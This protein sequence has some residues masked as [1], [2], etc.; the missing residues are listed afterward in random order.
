MSGSQFIHVEGYARQASAMKGAR[1]AKA[2]EKRVAKVRVWTAREILAES[3]REVQASH[4]VPSPKPPTSLF[5]DLQAL[6]D[7]LDQP[8]TV[9]VK[10]QRVDTPILLAGVASAPWPPGDPRSTAWHDD[11]LLHL[12]SLYGAN[13]RAVVAHVDEPYDHVHF[14]AAMPDL[15]PVRSLH[16]GMTAR[17]V[18]KAAG[19]AGFAQKAAYDGA[20]VAWQN[21]YHVDVGIKHGHARKGPA[22]ARL[23]REEWRARQGDAEQAAAA[24]LAV[25][26]AQASA[27]AETVTLLTEKQRQEKHLANM[28]AAHAYSKQRAAELDAREAVLVEREVRVE[29]KASKLKAL[30]TS[31]YTAMSKLYARMTWTDKGAIAHLLADVDHIK[32]DFEKI[33]PATPATKP[34]DDTAP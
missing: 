33:E 7:E 15:A 4:H 11:V 30:L 27:K 16:P 23:S 2:G 14:Y 18:V 21:A 3:M 20:M 26:K 24:L 9:R 29:K 32:A 12:K 8:Q 13:L 34:K 19:G 25:E 1:R 17:D 31:F 10:G 22:R 28:S 5:G 6:A